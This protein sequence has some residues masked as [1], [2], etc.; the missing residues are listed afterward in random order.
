MIKRYA[1]FAA[2]HKYVHLSLVALLFIG[3]AIITGLVLWRESIELMPIYLPLFGL[4]IFMA[5]VTKYRQ[6]YLPS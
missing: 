2:A 1:K 6:R 3:M 5:R 4:L